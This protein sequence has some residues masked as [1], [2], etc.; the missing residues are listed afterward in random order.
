MALALSFAYCK[1]DATGASGVGSE[2]FVRQ[3]CQIAAPCCTAAG[4]SGGGCETAVSTIVPA[5]LDAE[6]G[7]ACLDGLKAASGAEHFCTSG[8]ILPADAARLVPACGSLGVRGAVPVGGACND[9]VTGAECARSPQGHVACVFGAGKQVCQVQSLGGE[10]DT[11]VEDSQDNGTL[12]Y[13]VSLDVEAKETG[14]YCDRSKGLHCDGGK[15]TKQAAV[16]GACAD[17]ASCT[18]DAYCSFDTKKC[19]ARAADDTSCRIDAECASRSCDNATKKCSSTGSPSVLKT[20][21]G[22]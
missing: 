22:G 9:A 14:T 5:Q 13:G 18:P 11:C 15:C 16:G 8:L 7:K 20:T 6:N 10:G 1:H 12:A 17:D 3:Y 2:D 19:T 21:C 4:V